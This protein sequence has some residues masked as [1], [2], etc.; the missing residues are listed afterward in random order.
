VTE[1]PLIV[2]RALLAGAL[3][4]GFSVL[5]EM[6]RPKS[7]AGIFAAAPSIALASLLV[8]GLSKGT[9]ALTAAGAG[10]VLGAIVLGIAL[11]IGIDAVKR[12]G[13]LTGSLAVIGAWL[14][15]AAALYAVVF[16]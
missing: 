2:A 1:A 9:S 16:R 10:M 4:V 7:F 12:F 6:L 13:G 5:G 14:V 11:L 8:V 15:G 3:V